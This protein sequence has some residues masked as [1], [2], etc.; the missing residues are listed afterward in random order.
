MLDKLK[1][2]K[3]WA[4]FG[5]AVAILAVE[6]FELPIDLEAIY[7]IAGVG[8]VYIAGQSLVDARK[9]EPGVLE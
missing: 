8:S 7:A 9:S 3:L 4:A 1:S 6:I 2:R 5:T